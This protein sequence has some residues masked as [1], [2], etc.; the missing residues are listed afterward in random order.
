MMLMMLSP[1][2]IWAN[3]A[4]K[5]TPFAPS[6][7]LAARKAIAMSRILNRD[8]PREFSREDLDQ[9]RSALL[10]LVEANREVSTL[11]SPKVAGKAGNDAGAKGDD[12]D[13]VRGQIQKMSDKE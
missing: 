13:A 1:S 7:A 2:L 11:F 6:D 9:M 8:E 3:S 4:E 10:E 5:S 12:F